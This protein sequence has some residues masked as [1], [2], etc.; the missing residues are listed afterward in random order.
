MLS[1]TR[2]TFRFHCI[3]FLT[4]PLHAESCCWFPFSIPRTTIFAI[5]TV[6]YPGSG[7]NPA[8]EYTVTIPATD[9]RPTSRLLLP[10]CLL[11]AFGIPHSGIQLSGFKIQLVVLRGSTERSRLVVSEIEPSP[12][13]IRPGNRPPIQSSGFTGLLHSAFS[14][15]FFALALSGWRFCATCARHPSGG[16]IS[17]FSSAAMLNRNSAA[18]SKKAETCSGG[19]THRLPNLV[20]VAPRIG[21]HRIIAQ[22]CDVCLWMRRIRSTELVLSGPPRSHFVRGSARNWITQS[23]SH[24][25]RRY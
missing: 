15:K 10:A 2:S 6:V 16:R 22:L 13:F 17:R 7:R 23:H 5:V 21:K 25:H 11:P 3:S 24:G 8:S 19:H 1:G 4:K 9:T 12:S 14:L 20:A 18:L